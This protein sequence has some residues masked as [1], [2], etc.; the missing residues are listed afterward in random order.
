MENPFPFC[1]ILENNPRA[2]LAHV[3]DKDSFRMIQE[4][5]EF[6]FENKLYS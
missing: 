3:S 1:I 2:F 5:V 4:T 6:P